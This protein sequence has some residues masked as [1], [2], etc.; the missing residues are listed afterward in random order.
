MNIPFEHSGHTKEDW[1]R[2]FFKRQMM[3]APAVLETEAGNIIDAIINNMTEEGLELEVVSGETLPLYSVLKLQVK[4][5]F[6]SQ[7]FAVW[8]SGNKMGLLLSLP[9]HRAVIA[10]LAKFYPAAVQAVELIALPD[11]SGG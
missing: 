8:A 7:S 1:E 10:S 5:Y 4:G 11:N 9:V 6:S 2:R 3:R